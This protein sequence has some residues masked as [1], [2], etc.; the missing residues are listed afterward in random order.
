[1]IYSND[2]KLSLSGWLRQNRKTEYNTALK[3]QKFLLLYECFTKACGEKADFEYLRGYR[4]GPVFSQV[5]GDYT[6][7]RVEFNRAADES[8]LS[9][10]VTINEERAVKC[11]F[12]VSVLSENELSEFTHSMNLWKSKAKWIL[13]GEHQVDLDENDFDENDFRLISTLDKM[14]PIELIKNSSVVEI[15]NHYF[16]FRKKDRL[17]LTEQHFDVLSSLAESG[18]LLNPVY[19]DIDERGRLIVD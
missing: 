19:V 10:R 5:W 7:E 15:N 16:V 6:R 2:R 11:A 17:K 18:Q 9:G 14:Y 1:M 12:V 4:R 3:L 13:S 8:C